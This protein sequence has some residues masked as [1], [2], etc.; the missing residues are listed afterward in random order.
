MLRVRVCALLL[1]GLPGLLVARQEAA[2]AVPAE[3]AEIRFRVTEVRN[4]AGRLTCGLFDRDD[5][6]KRGMPGAG[7]HIKDGEALCVFRN[8]PPGRY[9]IVAYHDENS[10]RRLDMNFLRVP[11]EGICSSNNARGLFRP[12]RFKKASFDYQGGTLELEARLRY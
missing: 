10:N 12:P 2:D 5:W 9:G 4:E 7:G 8:V 11:K 1:V 6:L 3:V